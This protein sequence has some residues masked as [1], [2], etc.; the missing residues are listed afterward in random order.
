MGISIFAT[1]HKPM[2]NNKIPKTNFKIGLY[3]DRNDVTATE[4]PSALNKNA[5][6]K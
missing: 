5:H 4:T 6:K 2:T 3:D 1:H